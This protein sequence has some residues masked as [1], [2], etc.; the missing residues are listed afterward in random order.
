MQKC[1]ETQTGKYVCSHMYL[2]MYFECLLCFLFTSLQL[3]EL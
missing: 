3:F 1:K 2:G